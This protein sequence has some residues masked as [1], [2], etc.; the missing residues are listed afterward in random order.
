MT[1]DPLINTQPVSEMSLRVLLHTLT[2]HTHTLIHTHARAHNNTHINAI[3]FHFK[4]FGERLVRPFTTHSHMQDKLNTLSHAQT[5][6]LT[7][8]ISQAGHEHNTLADSDDIFDDAC[9]LLIPAHHSH[10]LAGYHQ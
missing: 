8:S 4:R 5:A 6:M 2:A 3:A 7:L 10:S 9:Y 1:I